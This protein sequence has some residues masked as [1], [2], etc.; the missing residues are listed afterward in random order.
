[1]VTARPM[2]RALSLVGHLDDTPFEVDIVDERVLE[3]LDGCQA[4]DV[5]QGVR[6]LVTVGAYTLRAATTPAEVAAVRAEIDRALERAGR[7]TDEVEHQLRAIVGE[8]GELDETCRRAEQRI[9][10]AIQ[11]ALAA[12][13]D[14]DNPSSLLARV[15]A[16]NGPVAEIVTQTRRE[17]VEQVAGMLAHHQAAISTAIC[18]LRDL[19]P[20]SGLGTTLGRL[21]QSVNDLG[22]VLARLAGTASERRRGTAKGV[23]YE[24]RVAAILAEMAILAGDRVER[25]GSR[26]G[27]RLSQTGLSLRGDL[28][29]TVG[30]SGTAIVEIMNRASA[31]LTGS[32]LEQEL[33]QALEN[34]GGQYAVAVTAVDCPALAGGPLAV[35]G[36]NQLVVRYDP[37]EGSELG[38]QIA[39]RLARQAVI[40]AARSEALDVGELRR[41]VE[42]IGNEM[43][44]LAEARQQLAVAAQC[45][46]KSSE[47][48]AQYERRAR[49]IISRLISSLR[50]PA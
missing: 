44:M 33:S 27:N 23:A 48:L 21:E 50:Q 22:M 16:A 42:G 13:T 49:L 4:D 3:Y 36:R 9:Q 38:L 37:D 24:E 10:G 11:E 25:T 1:M 7:V 2:V 6:T 26:P 15:A 40:S 19:P 20:G 8:G 47:L 43:R 45:T 46:R 18:E 35:L 39:Y 32:A 29:I 34:R 28:V 5:G 30:D 41:A 31:R 14:V 12:Q 17:I